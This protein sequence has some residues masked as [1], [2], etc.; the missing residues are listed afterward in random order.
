MTSPFVGHI[1][2][3]LLWTVW[4]SQTLI[5]KVLKG[6]HIKLNRT[7]FYAWGLVNPLQGRSSIKIMNHLA[8]RISDDR[9]RVKDLPTSVCLDL[10]SRFLE[11]L[12]S[13][14]PFDNMVHLGYVWF[15][16]KP[17]Q[18]T[19]VIQYCSCPGFF[20][21]DVRLAMVFGYAWQCRSN[22]LNKKVELP[23]PEVYT[24]GDVPN[25]PLPQTPPLQSHYFGHFEI[26]KIWALYSVTFES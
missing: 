3:L 5:L 25:D 23:G 20:E 2:H 9:N 19:V 26:D 13:W 7:V 18:T 11:L 21:S 4:D 15:K 24:S 16:K 14:S 17:G 1:L 10:L 12:R 22:C 6:Q 8:K